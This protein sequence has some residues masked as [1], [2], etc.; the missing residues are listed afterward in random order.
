M[1]RALEADLALI[2]HTLSPTVFP[3]REMRPRAEDAG[4]SVMKPGKTT[5][6]FLLTIKKAA[7]FYREKGPGGF[8]LRILERFF[9][10][11]VG[12]LERVGFTFARKDLVFFETRL[13]GEGFESSDRGGEMECIWVDERELEV[14]ENYFD[15]WFDKQQALKRLQEGHVLFAAK[16]NGQL[17]AY[18]WI[19]VG[20]VAIP[21][22]DLC[23]SIPGDSAWVAY[24]FTAADQRGKGIA[25]KTIS[26]VL[27]G[28]RQQGYRHVFVVIAPCNTVSQ[29]LHQRAGFV[30]Y[31]HMTAK[32]FFFRGILLLKYYWVKDK[33]S[34][35]KK[36]FFGR[37]ENGQSGLWSR[38]SRLR[39]WEE[40]Q[41]SGRRP[42]TVNPNPPLRETGRTG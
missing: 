5:H 27:Q 35:R 12:V 38:F 7:A 11:V 4:S 17:A 21:S 19:E 9:E 29:R 2:L 1:K 33:H 24:V 30:A 6:R 13:E 41:R 14:Q 18:F 23:F 32:R 31:Q 20:D 34:T 15:G 8:L 42:M 3:L 40:E 28:L 10:F 26:R 37:A 25:S 16:T 36:L 39:R 22:L